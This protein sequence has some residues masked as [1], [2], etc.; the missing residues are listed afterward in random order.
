[1]GR[2]RRKTS[3]QNA[4]WCRTQLMIIVVVIG[5]RIAIAVIVATTGDPFLLFISLAIA[6]GL[7]H[8]YQCLPMGHFNTAINQRLEGSITTLPLK[9]CLK[10]LDQIL[11]V[12]AHARRWLR[13]VIE[14]SGSRLLQLLLDFSGYWNHGLVAVEN[15]LRNLGTREMLCPRYSKVSLDLNARDLKGS[16]KSVES[17]QAEEVAFP[18]PWTR[19]EGTMRLP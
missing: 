17:D 14:C 2:G 19:S 7:F 16:V 18:S 10:H 1:M 8:R 3:H 6:V 12:T 15:E 9:H 5:T 13:H 4:V 11:S